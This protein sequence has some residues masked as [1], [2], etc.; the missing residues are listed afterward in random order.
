MNAPKKEQEEQVEPLE[1]DSDLL[2]AFTTLSLLSSEEARSEQ[3][4]TTA[5][6]L[7]WPSLTMSPC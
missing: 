1:G 6:F 5:T 3:N 2:L 7:E 4:S